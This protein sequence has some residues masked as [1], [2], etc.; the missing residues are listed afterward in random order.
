MSPISEH[1][2][3]HVNNLIVNYC[4]L[5]KQFSSE[6]EFCVREFKVRSFEEICVDQR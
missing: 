3:F 6:L 5:K 1:L 4:G 2:R